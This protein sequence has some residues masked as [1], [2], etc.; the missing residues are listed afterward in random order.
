MRGRILLLDGK[1][2]V[3]A[4][5]KKLRLLEQTTIQSPAG[6]DNQFLQSTTDGENGDA[7]FERGVNQRHA[8]KITP[9]VGVRLI[10]V[11]TIKVRLHIAGAA[12]QV[13]PVQFI[14][15]RVQ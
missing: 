4:V 10:A 13:D 14:N 3:L 9:G 5:F 2:G 1:F 15:D 12:W 7:P 6:G 8:Q 11:F